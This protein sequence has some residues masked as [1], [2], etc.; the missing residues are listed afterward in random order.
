METEE[1][2]TQRKRHAFL[3]IISKI[4]GAYSCAVRRARSSDF[5]SWRDEAVKRALGRCAP[6]NVAM[7]T[8][9]LCGVSA[10]LF[11]LHSLRLNHA[12]LLRLSPVLNLPPSSLA[13]TRSRVRPRYSGSPLR[14]SSSQPER[15]RVPTFLR[16]SFNGRRGGSVCSAFSRRTPR[17]TRYSLWRRDLWIG[18]CLLTPRTLNSAG[19]R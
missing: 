3:G 1:R 13:P 7:Y 19:L 5:C 6:L 8:S 14:M 11:P 10:P 15:S 18:E 16:A 9:Q 17:C 12:S 4:L 2:R